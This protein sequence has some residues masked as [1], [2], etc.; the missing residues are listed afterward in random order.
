MS[1][2]II[3]R[4][5][6][7]H[8]DELEL[9]EDYQKFKKRIE[10]EL[11]EG[12]SSKW[13]HALIQEMSESEK[14]QF[15]KHI[16][17]QGLR[18]KKTISDLLLMKEVAQLL[19]GG[20]EI[21]Y[22]AKRRLILAL[23][24]IVWPI[25]EMNEELEGL[26][27][28]REEIIREYGIWHYYWS[29]YFHP[30]KGSKLWEEEMHR[31]EEADLQQTDTK[32]KQEKG[33]DG[34]NSVLSEQREVAPDEKDERI[35]KLEKKVKR[36]MELRVSLEKELDQKRKEGNRLEKELAAQ[37]EAVLRL[38]E[39]NEKWRNELEKLRFEWGEEK[40][41]FQ[42]RQ[43]EWVDERT[44]LYQEQKRLK[45]ELEASRAEMNAELQKREKEIRE[46]RQELSRIQSPK[47][48]EERI[49]DLKRTLYTDVAKINQRLP[50]EMGRPEERVLR[51]KLRLRL[52]FL[53]QL[54]LFKERLEQENTPQ[55]SSTWSGVKES[56]ERILIPAEDT[57]A[58]AVEEAIGG[59][60]P[61]SSGTEET[62]PKTGIFYR[63][64][65]GGYIELED[66]KTFSISESL[67]L[68]LG[69]EHGA[70]VA[71]TPT[72]NGRY[73]IK[74]LYPGDDSTSQVKK[75]FGYVELGEYHRWY[76][77]D[78]SN[79]EL[80]FLIH[81]KDL[82]ILQPQDG[83]PCNF[84]V[85]EGNHIARISRLYP[86][87]GSG[88]RDGAGKGE[89]RPTRMTGKKEEEVETEEEKERRIPDLTGCRIAIVGGQRKW[90]EDV[91][92]ETGA[93]LIHDDGQT[94]ERIYADLKRSNALF[95]LLTANSHRAT[96][97]CMEIAKEYAIPHYIIR[98]S[99]SNLRSML[100]QHQD[101]IRGL[102]QD[103]A[104]GM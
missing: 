101:E 21:H 65:H 85:F 26:I 24:Q 23:M 28:R 56:P 70:G 30:E 31:I 9:D 3:Y 55:G 40:R 94:P 57:E 16:L 83:A 88:E 51:H 61:V 18:T 37:R 77:V 84:N 25:I 95:L 44:Q 15:A 89:P 41:R 39:M 50:M 48:W 53:D 52:D 45:Q 11:K 78:H 66:G 63:R 62:E 75:Y 29:V 2:K 35:E 14:R 22:T 20:S 13:I 38:Q 8:H 102:T 17:V 98:G 73:H 27:S 97:G 69:L 5:L 71:C 92:S 93:E 80:R 54:D 91:V 90:F 43:Q 82:N 6:K 4:R 10:E 12:Y 76:C 68:M 79:P 60:A 47:G 7:E 59:T 86:L 58:E 64:D 74:L 100:L 46:L 42:T 103:P 81:Q 67:V 19:R 34:E 49:D 33:P 36:E 99:K 87:E 1:S 104:A 72:E 32:E 96:W